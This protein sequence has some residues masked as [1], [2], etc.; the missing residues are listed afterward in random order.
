MVN[1]Y[2]D[3]LLGDLVNDKDNKAGAEDSKDDTAYHAAADTDKI[4]EEA[5]HS[6]AEDTEDCVSDKATAAFHDNSGK[7][8]DN[9]TD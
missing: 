4:T 2:S 1:W 7:I 3:V 5:S 6:T 9:S 8:T